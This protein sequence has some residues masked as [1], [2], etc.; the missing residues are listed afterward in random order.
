M[1]LVTAVRH[2][3]FEDLG[4]FEPLLET[5]GFHIQYLD[6]GVDD[7][8]VAGEAETDLLVVLGG[9][10]GAYEEE[11]YPFLTSEIRLMERRLS[12]GLPTM[13]ICWGAQ[14]M[15]HG[16][17]LTSCVV[18]GAAVYI[19]CKLATRIEPAAAITVEFR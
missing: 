11:R 10:I 8:S 2:L 5:M 17:P 1:P 3:A 16:P 9:P 15:A 6:A 12:A 18:G 19:A 13:G 7:L 4:A 14:L